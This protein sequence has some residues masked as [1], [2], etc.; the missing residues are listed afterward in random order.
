VT[1][2][3]LIPRK[4]ALVRYP[5]MPWTIY[6]PE[7]DE[8]EVHMPNGVAYMVISSSASTYTKSVNKTCSQIIR[9]F[10]RLNLQTF[11]IMGA[12]D[13]PWRFR[14]RKYPDAKVTRIMAHFTAS[15]IRPRFN[16]AVSVSLSEFE[17]WFKYLLYSVR[18]NAVVQEIFFMNI[19]Q[20]LYFSPC[21][22]GN[23]HLTVLDQLLLPELN[24]A[25]EYSELIHISSGDC[26][27]ESYNA[28]G[29]P[30]RRSTY[31]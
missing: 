26:G 23:L 6:D 30:G 27:R 16:G 20:S 18:V 24:D 4:E 13:T 31:Y 8:E 28:G 12:Q 17:L 25:I 14:Q 7:L 9:I 11:I 3:K 1:A 22:Y 29:I 5:L 10:N 15:G 19:K 21:Q 2:I